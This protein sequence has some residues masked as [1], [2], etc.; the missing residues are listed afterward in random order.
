VAEFKLQT[1]VEFEAKFEFEATF[2]FEIKFNL[3][4]SWSCSNI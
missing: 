2:E 1:K 4:Q 3:M